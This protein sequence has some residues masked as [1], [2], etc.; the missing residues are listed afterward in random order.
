MPPRRY[1]AA[2]TAA[3]IIGVSLVA[4]ACGSGSKTSATS[5][6]ATPAQTANGVGGG[7]RRFNGTPNP[8]LQTSIAEGTPPPFANRTPN[9]GLQTSIAEGTRPPFGRGGTPPAEV[10]TAIAEGTPASALRGGFGGSG[11]GRVLP[12]VATVLGMS[13]DDLQTAL[14]APGASIETVAAAHGKD[15]ATLRQALILAE[16]Q[17]LND[18]VSSGA[19]TQDMADQQATQFESNLDSRIDR[20]GGFAPGGPGDGGSAP[21]Q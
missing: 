15:R 18:M 1:V 20:V 3:S 21:A 13:Q 12:L 7:G 17:Q 19:I 5:N 14:Q 6:T 2:I 9:P 4:V 11:G 10:Q 8:D 16:R